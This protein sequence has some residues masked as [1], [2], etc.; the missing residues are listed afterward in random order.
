MD[1]QTD[2]VEAIIR[3][4]ELTTPVATIARTLNFPQAT[5]LYVIEHRRLP[6]HKPQWIQTDLFGGGTEGGAE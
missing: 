5:V 4:W 1:E 2:T 6:P 3:L